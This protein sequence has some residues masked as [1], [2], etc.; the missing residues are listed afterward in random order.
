MGKG[1]KMLSEAELKDYLKNLKEGMEFSVRELMRVSDWMARDLIKWMTDYSDRAITVVRRDKTIENSE[2]N[3]LFP[4]MKSYPVYQIGSVEE[5]V[6][7]E[8][9]VHSHLR[10]P[11][12]EMTAELMSQD[13]LVPV[14][15]FIS[16]GE[17]I[18][19]LSRELGIAKAAE[20]LEW[21]EVLGHA[22]KESTPPML[23]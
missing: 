2:D 3:F 12:S 17:I 5:E 22:R 16:H 19:M 13:I 7:V 20:V 9:K 21:W 15:I 23:R 14:G 8:E 4:G 11:S 6:E 10:T 1:E 18:S